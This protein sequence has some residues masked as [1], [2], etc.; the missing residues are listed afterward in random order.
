[1]ARQEELKELWRGGP[2]GQ[3]C[4]LE[5]LKA[6]ALREVWVKDGRS[7][8]GMYAFIAGKVWK[9]GNPR[10]NPDP[11]SVKELLQ[12]IDDDDEDWFPAKQ[13]G[14]K[15]GRKRVLIG[16]KATSLCRAAKALKARKTEV[17]YPRLC[18][19][20]PNAVLNPDTGEPVDKGGSLHLSQR[21]LL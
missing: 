17:T 2:D 5:Q 16:A 6:W 9:N 15:R 12:K 21:G 20:A 7:T 13:Y 3:L 18:A 10:E 19:S 8:Y 1:M 4:A 11:V 14:E